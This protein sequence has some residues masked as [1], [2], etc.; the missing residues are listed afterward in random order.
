MADTPPSPSK[1][2]SEP[3]LAAFQLTGWRGDNECLNGVYSPLDDNSTVNGRPIFRHKTLLGARPGE[4]SYEMYWSDDTWYIG[5]NAHLNKKGPGGGK[6]LNGNDNGQPNGKGDGDENAA[7]AESA[8]NATNASLAG[9]ANH[10]DREDGR[11]QKHGADGGY[12]LPNAGQFI[13]YVESSAAHPTGISVG[14]KWYQR[15]LSPNSGKVA[16]TIRYHSQTNA[17]TAFLR[18]HFQPAEGVRVGAGV[19]VGM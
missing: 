19:C 8:N 15:K 2:S 18:S 9:Y 1:N 16:S 12:D 13:A 10:K 11:K 7:A 5:N 4:D 17:K 6:I 3:L 14:A